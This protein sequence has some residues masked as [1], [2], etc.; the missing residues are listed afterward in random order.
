MMPM[1]IPAVMKNMAI[2]KPILMPIVMVIWLALRLL[3]RLVFGHDAELCLL[4]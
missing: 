1:Y 4:L 2:I 3:V